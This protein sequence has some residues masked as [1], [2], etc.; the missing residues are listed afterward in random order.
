MSQTVEF[1]PLLTFE[2]DYEILNHYP[3]IIRK[4]SNHKIIKE[5]LNNKN[6]PC[7]SL[8]KRNYLKHVLIAKQFISNPDNLPQVDH[9]NRD[10]SDYHLSNLRYVSSSENN[11]NR[12]V[13]TRNTNIEYEYVDSIS[14]DSIVVNEYNGHIFENYYYDNAFYFYNGINYRKLFINQRKNNRLFVCMKDTNNKIIQVYYSTFKKQHD[15]I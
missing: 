12:S 3:F 14:D 4:K 8:N 13:S 15:L 11:M 1:V 6:Y 7:V 5:G 10:R 2:N 9:I